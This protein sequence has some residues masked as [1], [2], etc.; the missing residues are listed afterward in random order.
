MCTANPPV[1]IMFIIAT[2]G[3]NAGEMKR[4]ADSQNCHPIW[5]VPIAYASDFVERLGSAAQAEGIQG[6]S[7]YSM[8]FTDS[9]ARN[10]PEVALFQKWM[11][12]THPDA[13]LELYAMYSWAAAKLFVQELKAIGPRVTRK[14]FLDHIRTITAFDGDG[15]VNRSNLS[16][17]TASNCYILWQIHNGV[18]ERI[19]TP[20]ATYRCDHDFIPYN[21]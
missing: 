6:H 15:L 2:T 5:I 1:Q 10:I 8:F 7:L 17:H 20:A 13:A 18:Y 9:E 12:A 16:T 3:Q 21:A 11:K 4:E 14:A 19:E